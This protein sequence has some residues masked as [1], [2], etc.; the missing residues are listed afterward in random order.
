[1]STL[2]QLDEPR[3]SAS[4]SRPVALVGVSTGLLYVLVYAM[5]HMIAPSQQT[6]RSDLPLFVV[7]YVAAT[8]AVFLLY[9]TIVRMA[10]SGCLRDPRARLLALGIPVVFNIALAVSPPRLSIDVLTYI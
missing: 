1:M 3:A 7:V 8:L 2:K 10:A 5:E 4:P 6:S 9:L